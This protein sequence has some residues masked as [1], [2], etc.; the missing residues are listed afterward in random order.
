MGI[1]YNIFKCKLQSL[2]TAKTKKMF[3]VFFIESI[4]VKPF[5]RRPFHFNE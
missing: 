1:F 5:N 4:F 2:L 3:A